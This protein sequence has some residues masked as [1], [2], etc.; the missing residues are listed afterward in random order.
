[1]YFA[2]TSSYN[3][4]DIY[5]SLLNSYLENP[6]SEQTRLFFENIVKTAFQL[7][8]GLITENQIDNTIYDLI[9]ELVDHNKKYNRQYFQNIDPNNI[10]ETEFR[11]LSGILSSLAAEAQ[12]FA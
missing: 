10:G 12:E 9:T 1:M 4:Y 11:T 6:H 7:S 8:N 5:R 3:N 2:D